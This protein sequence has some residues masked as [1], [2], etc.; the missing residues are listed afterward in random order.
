MIVGHIPP[1]LDHFSFKAEWL[2]QFVVAYTQVIDQYADVVAAQLFAHLHQDTF[3]F[4]P[5]NRVEY[6]IFLVGAVSPIFEN[7]PSF[8]VWSY[9]GAQLLDFTVYG[10][11]LDRHGPQDSLEFEERYSARSAYGLESLAADEW[12]TKVATPLLHN[13]SLWLRYIDNLWLRTS[14]K[15]RAGFLGSR[16][17]RIRAACAFEHLQSISFLECVESHNH[18]GD[19]LHA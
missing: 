18:T 5:S 19:A 11:E 17:F 1:T 8:R 6:P 16:D 14:G 7:N 9:K 4:M 3:R 12:R 13:D 15:E 2:D 10:A